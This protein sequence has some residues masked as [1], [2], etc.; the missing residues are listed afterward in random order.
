MPQNELNNHFGFW[1]NLT[2]ISC[3]YMYDIW[4]ESLCAK[5][6]THERD[7]NINELSFEAMF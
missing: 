6:C 7:V 5:R 2:R 3:T 4:S 1:Q